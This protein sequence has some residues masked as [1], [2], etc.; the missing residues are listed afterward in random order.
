[1]DVDIDTE[2]KN[3]FNSGVENPGYDGT[4]GEIEMKNLNT[5]D[6]SSRRGS[7]DTTYDEDTS[8]GDASVTTSLLEQEK[9]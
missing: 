9:N 6:S 3:P 2:K 1:M 5:Y 4:G 8:V 7:A